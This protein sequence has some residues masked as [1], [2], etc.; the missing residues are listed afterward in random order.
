MNANQEKSQ[1]EVRCSFALIRV[2]VPRKF[3]HGIGLIGRRGLREDV[4]FLC[5]HA[6]VNLEAVGQHALGR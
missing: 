6:A 5:Q 1:F 3:G 4:V 2:H